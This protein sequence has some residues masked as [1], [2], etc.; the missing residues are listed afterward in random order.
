MTLT[1]TRTSTN[2]F[3]SGNFAPV[4][5]ELDVADLPVRGSIPADLNGR[6]LRIGPN[7]V[8]A[9][10]P[11]T[12]HWFTG[13]GMVHGVRIR[14]GRAEWYRNRYVRSDGVTEAKGWPHT[15]GPRHGMGDGTA[16]TNVIGHA[17]RTFAIVEAGGLPVELSYDLDTKEMTNFDGTLPGSFTAH[18][19]RDP[20]TGE[21]HGIVYYWEWDYVQYVV[22]GTDGR[23]AKTVDIA[24]PGKPM[25]HDCAITESKIVVLDLPVTFDLDA[26][27]KGFPTLPYTWNADYGAR[28]GLLPRDATSGDATVW[29]E[30]DMCFVYHPLNAYDLPDGRVVCDVIRHPKMFATNLNGPDE[31]LPILVRWTIDPATRRVH[32]EVLDDR[33]QEFPRLDERRTGR[34]HRYGYCAAFGTGVEHGPALKHDLERGT[35]EV[36]EYGPGRVTLEPVFVP[37]HDDAAEDEGWIMSYVYDGTTDS[38]DVVILDAQDFSGEPVAVISLPQRVPFGF[39]G[40]WVPDAG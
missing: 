35:S 20:R 11:Q 5:D 7:P 3:L 27:M 4:D 40:N 24:V 23:V 26:A 19:H 25:I 36:H 28:V 13:S 32:Q 6:L 29:C 31:G 38:S 1:E 33:G 12:Y 22:V 37:R 14:G 2:V 17:D 39:H 21:L 8:A 10:D 30:V 15:P 9:P 18:P 16:N 34:K